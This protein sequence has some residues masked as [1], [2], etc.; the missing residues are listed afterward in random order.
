MHTDNK[1]ALSRRQALLAGVTASLFAGFP[2]LSQTRASI[3]STI[4]VGREGAPLNPFLYGGF[5]EHIG[6]LIN[7]SLWSEVLDD[8]KFYNA[9]D[10]TPAPKVE[11]SVSQ[12]RVVN[13]WVPVGPDNAVSMNRKTPW[14]GEQS[15]V[16]ALTASEPRGIAQSGLILRGR[17]DYVG[18]VVVAADGQADISA[19]LI[20]GNGAGDRQTIRVP[21]GKDWS[22]APLRFL[23]QADTEEAR[24]E[25]TGTGGGTFSIGAVSLMPADNIKG[26]RAD[27]I[28]LMK[29][30]D[31][32]ILRI[33][34][35]N[36]ISSYDWKNTIGDPD[37]RPPILDPVWNFA[38]PN[39]VGV[40]ELLQMC[41]LINAEP[42]WSVSTGFDEPRSGAEQVEYING[43]ADTEWG[44]K[45]AANGHP[46]PYRVKYWNIGNEM[47]GHWQMGHIPLKQYVV[48]HNLFADAMRKV[49][50]SIY[51]IAPGGFADEMTTGQGIFIEGQ[52]QVEFGSD[53]DW[54]YGMFEHAWGKFDA[55]A[56]HAYPP[57]NKKFDI[58]TGKLFDVQR[59]L[60]EWA[61]QPANRVLTMVECW[62]EY[63][64]RFPALKD[65]KVK[66]FFDEYAYSFRQT[67]KTCLAM[68][69]CLHEFFR[70][71][72]FIDMA[73][74]T[75][76]TGWMDVDR[77][78]SVISA[79]GRLY[80]MYNQHFGTIPVAVTGNSPVPAPEYPAG[81]DQPRVNAGS[82]TYPLDLSAA[83]TADRKALI[84]AVV[85]ATEEAHPLQLSLEGFK[86]RRT[87]RSW[88][89]T[90][91]SLE[92]QNQVG[93]PPEVVIAEST[94]STS[95]PLKIAPISVA[96]YEFVR[97]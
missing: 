61:R 64:K 31:C 84:V 9:I 93:K 67:L 2:A 26:F 22:T 78:R 45:R 5:L 38:Q 59:P 68:G 97:A 19:T 29:E 36:F 54:A 79:T 28:A 17:T 89:L 27:T 73:G 88:K 90:A 20:W 63:K 86:V 52:P 25:I 40:D 82:A 10:S 91:A 83:L 34:G 49:D 4:Q 92:A 7:H 47:Y 48:K 56:T 71:S 46:E 95:T 81:G 18:R 33:P 87:G 14:V 3:S 75:M 21:A 51:I 32:K 77:T 23:P 24:L 13:K 80:Q 43:A 16:V 96:L 94:F 12:M 15:P 11:G 60:V 41:Q 44:A 42:S 30:M 72:D 35:G 39:D 37:K 58:K 1:L 69:M 53:R 57:E 70:H 85:N 6:N 62:E 50:P 76:A 66:V 74:Y 8:R 65:G 55:L